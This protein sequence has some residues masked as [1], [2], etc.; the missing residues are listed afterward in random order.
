MNVKLLYALLICLNI[1]AGFWYQCLS[2]GMVA[3]QDFI[4]KFGK[5]CYFW[6]CPFVHCGPFSGESIGKDQ[7]VQEWIKHRILISS[8]AFLVAQVCLPSDVDSKLSQSSIENHSLPALQAG[9]TSD[10]VVLVKALTAAKRNYQLKIKYTCE[11][12]LNRRRVINTTSLIE[13]V[14]ITSKIPFQVSLRIENS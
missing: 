10:L 13:T 12:E 7:W 14:T 1:L 9:E 6:R 5:R 8:F 4:G 11:V 2:L 3:G